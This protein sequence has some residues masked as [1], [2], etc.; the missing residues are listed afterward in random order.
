MADQSLLPG[1]IDLIN[2]NFICFFTTEK[3]NNNKAY[4]TS[5]RKKWII[6]MLLLLVFKYIPTIIYFP[7]RPI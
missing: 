7:M 5:K 3:N 2:S 6:F 1:I 4:I